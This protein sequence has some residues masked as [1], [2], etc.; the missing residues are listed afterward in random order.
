[1]N[2]V[3]QVRPLRYNSPG[4]FI[5]D[6]SVTLIEQGVAKSMGR[7]R[8]GTYANMKLRAEDMCPT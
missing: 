2:A 4:S 6:T 1:M 8:K 3:R 5:R 7:F